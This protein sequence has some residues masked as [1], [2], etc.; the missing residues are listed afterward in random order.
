MKII[1]LHHTL[2]QSDRLTSN[3]INRN[4]DKIARFLPCIAHMSTNMST[5]DVTYLVSYRVWKGHHIPTNALVHSGS[6]GH[7]WQEGWGDATFDGTAFMSVR[8]SKDGQRTNVIKDSINETSNWK[9][10]MRILHIKSNTYHVTFNTFGRL[11]PIKRK[12][13]YSAMKEIF[14]SKCFYYKNKKSNN[15][16]HKPSRKYLES[17][18]N[19]ST[20]N[21]NDYVHGHGCTFQNKAILTI[22]T[23]TLKPTFEKIA[24]VCPAHHGTVEKN[25]AMFYDD[26]GKLA[27][28]YSITPWTFFDYQCKMRVIMRTTLFKRLAIYYDKTSSVYSKIIQFSCSTPLIPYTEHEYIGVGHFKIHYEDGNKLPVNSPGR[29]FL[30]ELKKKLGIPSYDFVKYS[31]KIHYELVYG[32]FVYTINRKTLKL[33]RTS[34]AFLLLSKRYPKALC[35]PSGIV[36]HNSTLFL[37]SYHENDINIKLWNVSRRELEALLI[38]DNN[39]PVETY[40]F[41]T[42]L[43]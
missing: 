7:P 27:Y 38:Y 36:Q 5:G 8:V 15:L 4:R 3:L 10:D 1:N 2:S 40:P 33:Q 43:Y 12:N 42:I 25:H 28:Q 21:V 6:A 34:K 9:V 19:L 14:K 41:E 26:K 23:K 39:S 20:E 17:I 22:N 31:H 29:L 30:S 18:N 24:L 35:Y 32:M 13:D 16:I 37:I 11:N